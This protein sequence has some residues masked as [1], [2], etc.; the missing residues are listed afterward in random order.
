[1]NEV[2]LILCIHNHQPVGNL[3]DVFEQAY[4]D[5]YLPFLDAIERFPEIRLVLHNTGPLLEWFERHAPDYLERVAGLVA[6]GQ[7][8]VLTGAFY[9]PILGAIPER[10]ALGQIAR[11]SE[12]VES[13][14]G[15]RPRGERASRP[16]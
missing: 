9:E 2:T 6:R 14:F 3:P 4:R 11:M 13:A 5:A 7:V 8:E 10:D 15:T 12:Y 16:R 1:M